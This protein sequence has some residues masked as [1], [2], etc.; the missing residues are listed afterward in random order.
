M[1]IVGALRL[2]AVGLMASVDPR[3]VCRSPIDER[4]T[5]ITSWSQVRSWCGGWEHET[6]RVLPPQVMV[7]YSWSTFSV[8]KRE[9][10]RYKFP[11]T[12]APTLLTLSCSSSFLTIS[13]VVSLFASSY[14]TIYISCCC[15]CAPG[16][17]GSRLTLECPGRHWHPPHSTL[18]SQRSPAKV[19][20]KYT[21]HEL[22][23]PMPPPALQSAWP[24]PLMGEMG[25]AGCPRWEGSFCT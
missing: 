5:C 17:C 4:I 14:I 3:L 7:E 12:H 8:I 13:S 9:R 6:R 22:R 15:W 10:T 25:K 11:L 21:D 18:G 16:P 24:A 20:G 1:A 23:F 2:N 19:K